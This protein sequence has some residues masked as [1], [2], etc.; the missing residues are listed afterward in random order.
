MSTT[1]RGFIREMGAGLAAITSA[2]EALAQGGP[3]QAGSERLLVDRPGQPEPAPVGVDRLPIEWYKGAA[4]RLKAKAAARGL[5]A[6]LLQSDHDI[7]YFT[8]C[9]RHSGERSTWVLMPVSESDTVYWYSPGIDRDLIESWWCTE[10][11]YYFC[12]PHAEGGF[13]N[14]G[15][16]ARGKRVN[17]WEWLLTG[18]KTRGLGDKAI[19][20]DGELSA[21]RRQSAR[22]IVPDARFVDISED[23]LGLRII[24]T[25]EEIAL[26]QR[27]YRYFDKVHA[28][29]RDYILEHGTAA[30]D[31]Q[32]GQALSAYGINLMMKDVRRDGRPHSAVG[33]EVTSQY[34]RAG[35]ATAYPHPNQFFHARVERGRPLYV[36]CDILLG[37]YGGECYR[38]YV[39]APWDAHHEKMWQ[40]VSDTVQ[41]MVEETRP[42]QVCSEVARKV[43]DH[44]IKNGMQAFIYHRPGHGQGQNYEGHQPPFLA[45]GD[46]SVVEEGMTFSVEPGLYDAANGIG[47]NPSDRLL[48]LKDRAVLMSRVPFSREWSFLKL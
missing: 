14:R 47:V 4:R 31:F 30:T 1:R 40:V 46:D 24:K 27:A 22:A 12:Y 6:V 10:N 44:Q 38:N 8:G 34:V 2:A 33:I 48:V 45:L 5:D 13:P 37:G 17:L 25:K 39:L 26:T 28:F 35:V 36:N 11:S 9:F 16:V 42:G 21:A 23:C 3:A 29:A 19:G 7:V 18:L 43:H 20:I 32:I 41:I 15:Q